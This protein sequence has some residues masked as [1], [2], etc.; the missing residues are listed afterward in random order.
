MTEYLNKVLKDLKEFLE[1]DIL[2]KKL[3]L[4]SLNISMFELIND[5]IINKLKCFFSDDIQLIG[6]KLVAKDETPIYVKEV[7]SLYKSDLFKSSA[8][9][10]LNQ[11]IIERSEY[12]ILIEFRNN[13]N[14]IAHEIMDML[15][16]SNERFDKEFPQQVYLIYKKICVWWFKEVE[17]TINPAFEH[18][19]RKT[20]DFEKGIEVQLFPIERIVTLIMKTNE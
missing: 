8:K 16:D 6:S 18:I 19:N 2:V 14:K 20:F 3:I 17:T 7:K 10:Y 13:R 11:E 5:Q 1:D 12:D 15:F 4:A 9:W